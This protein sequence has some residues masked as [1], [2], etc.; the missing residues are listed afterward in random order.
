MSF[1]VLQSF[2]LDKCTNCLAFSVFA[3][4]IY[5]SPGPEVITVFMINSTEHEIYHTNKYT[6]ID[7][8]TFISMINLLSESSKNSKIDSNDKN[9]KTIYHNYDVASGSEIT[10]CNKICKPLVVYRFSG[11]VMTSI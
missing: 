8:L 9:S 3:C 6:S 10:P 4:T 7:I 5:M 2:C 11:N 1:L